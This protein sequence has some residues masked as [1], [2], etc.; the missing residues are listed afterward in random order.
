MTEPLHWLLHPPERWADLSLRDWDGLL[1][2]A[3]HGNLLA[4]LA[5][6]VQPQI[7]T[8]PPQVQAHL[9]AALRLS[10]HQLQAIAWECRHLSRALTQLGIPVVL[11]KGAAYAMGGQP[12]SRGRLFGDIDLLVP[13]GAL[14]IV[15]QTLM[16]HGWRS[17]TTEAYDQRYYREWMH[18]LPPLIHAERLTVVDV[19]H[20]I[21][22]LTARSVPDA[23]LLLAAAVPI[24]GTP[25]LR[26]AP[27]DQVLHSACH[28]FHEGEP[29]N[30]LRDLHDLDALLREFGG[31]EGF[32][33]QLQSRAHQLNMA[34]VLMLALRY[35]Q[36]LL[37]TPMLVGVQA[38]V[39]QSAKVSS[40]KMFAL[41]AIYLRLLQPRLPERRGVGHHLAAT[42]LY[43]RGH[44]LRM[45]LH[46]LLLHLGRKAMLRLVKHNSREA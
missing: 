27:C 12:A 19:H 11:L 8:L 18:E 1:R 22:P 30:L 24:A 42:V 2:L 34:W 39:Q 7:E 35:C 21:L 25:F 14:P 3:R 31:D 46:L 26:L 17:D 10:A 5:E 13:R 41:D 32:W 33:P 44:A 36:R 28:L 29:R 9:L 6:Q 20:N 38:E 16:L 37:G 23:A 15:E 40:L 45:P 43:L 4:R